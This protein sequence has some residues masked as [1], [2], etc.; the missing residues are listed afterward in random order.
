VIRRKLGKGEVIVAGFW[1]GL[2]YSAKV[3]RPDFDMRAD[4]DAAVRALIAAPAL[5]RKVNR[6]VLLAEPLVE[7]VLLE[8]EVKRSVA[9]INWAYR[10]PDEKAGRRPRDLQVVENLRVELPGA[11]PVK[12]VRSLIHGPLKLDGGA[13]VLPKMEEIDLLIL[14]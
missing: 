6:P 14:E 9:L 12:S 2:T 1:A 7:V 13:V 10:H 8:K 5:E 3:R 4:F 11:G